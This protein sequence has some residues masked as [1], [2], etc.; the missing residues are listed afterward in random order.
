VNATRSARAL[1]R[2][3]TLAAA[4][5]TWQ[6]AAAGDLPPAHSEIPHARLAHVET[7][8]ADWLDATSAVAAIDSGLMTR[9]D[10]R[11]RRECA[12]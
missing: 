3:L 8:Y 1:L 7:Q 6:L 11:D 12:N 9:V 2:Y 10:G 4:L 5:A